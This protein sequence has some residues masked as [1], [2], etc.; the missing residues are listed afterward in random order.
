[1][2]PACTFCCYA[3]LWFRN[4][5]DA[6]SRQVARLR[7]PTKEAF[8]NVSATTGGSTGRGATSKSA[9]TSKQR[10]HAREVD[11]DKNFGSRTN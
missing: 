9:E 7:K 6:R 10:A 1:M 5:K 4:E 11:R 2:Y 8:A 3:Q